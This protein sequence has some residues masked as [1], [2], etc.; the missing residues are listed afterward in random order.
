M[1]AKAPHPVTRPLLWR[2]V[3]LR[4][5]ALGMVTA[6]L[7]PR[8]FAPEEVADRLHY[9]FVRLARWLENP[10]RVDWELRRTLETA[11]AL[12]VGALADDIPLAVVALAPIPDP[13]APDPK[14]QAPG[15]DDVQGPNADDLARLRTTHEMTALARS[16]I[17]PI[18]PT[19]PADDLA[20]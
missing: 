7:V 5:A 17:D 8:V 18:T 6:Q 12:P 20:A 16:V 13:Y 2:K 4:L 1:P 10:Q 3:N 11:L 19:M 15:A 14:H 9:C